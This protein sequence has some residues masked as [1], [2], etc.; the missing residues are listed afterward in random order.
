MCDSLLGCGLINYKEAGRYLMAARQD[1]KG[2][3][4]G[5]RFNRRKANHLAAEDDQQVL[6]AVPEHPLICADEAEFIED[7]AAL[8]DLIAHVREVGCFAYDT[9]FIGELTYS[10][11]FCLIQIATSTRVAVIDS[12]CGLDLTCVWE[13]L[14]DESVR[15]LVHAGSQDLEP[16][17]RFLDKA[18]ANIF[19]TQI[20][21]GFGALPYPL[22]LTKLVEEFVGIKLGKAL[23]FTSWDE[24][25]LSARHLR[26]AAD[27]VRYL[28]A[29]YAALKERL[30]NMGHLAW[31][32]GECERLCDPTQ[33]RFNP[34]TQARR[35]KGGKGLKP[36]EIAIL[37]ELVTV[38][39]AGAQKENSPPRAH[40]K[41]EVLVDMARGRGKT[42]EAIADLRGMPRQVA[43]EW[44]KLYLE[45]YERGV[46]KP[47]ETW[48]KPT[49]HEE[50]PRQRYRLD[51][52]WA[53]LQGYCFG[54]GIDP[55]L[56]GNRQQLADYYR[57]LK[58]SEFEVDPPLATGWR[59]AVV[60]SVLESLVDH[61]GD[62]HLNW[63]DHRLNA[64]AGGGNGVDQ[65]SDNS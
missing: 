41:D 36:K 58:G 47:R 17:V 30:E 9:E 18:P 31:A 23:T 59:R 54:R 20:G 26:Y 49:K 52:L 62:I 44:G 45:A 21:G 16:V 7:D 27:D 42:L 50:T 64:A 55:A 61:G 8:A 6:E 4:G 1:N 63:V 19:D 2:G 57:L 60:G 24:R 12:M 25:P 35:V 22:S 53:G 51:G 65:D 46:A 29:V 28:P 11:M 43:R 56:I 48:P 15:V 39:D 38:R 10:P 33:Y 13:L 34:I 5:A 32:E 37:H 40:L 3:A 14:A